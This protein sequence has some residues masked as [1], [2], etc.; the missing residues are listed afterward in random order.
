MSIP[1]WKPRPAPPEIFKDQLLPYKNANLLSKFFVHWIAPVTKV[2]WSRDITIDDLYDLTSDLQSGLLGDKLEA[3]FMK[4][5]PPSRRPAKYRDHL[6]SDS[7]EQENAT[8]ASMTQEIGLSWISR[9]FNKWTVRKSNKGHTIIEGDKIYDQSLFKA[10]YLTTWGQWWWMIVIKSTAI[11]M[12][13]CTRLVMKI[14]LTEITRAHNWHAVAQSGQST[15]G[16][17]PPKSVGYMFGVGIGMVITIMATSNLMYYNYWRARLMGKFIHSAITAMISRKAMRLSGKARVEMTN[18]RITTMLSVDSSFI[19][20]ATQQSSELI[21]FPL[22]VILYMGILIWQL[23]YCALVGFAVLLFTGPLKYW[24]FKHI[25]KL[26][27][28]QNEVIDIRVKFLSEILNNIRAVKLY[29]YESLF[30]EKINGMRKN[31]LGKFQ[32]NNLSNST[33]TATMAFLPTLAAILTFITYALT[34]HEL[35]VATVFSSLTYFGALRTPLADLPQ[36]VTNLS[37]ASVGIRRIGDLLRA[38]E[39]KS[40]IKIDRNSE[41]AIDVTGDFRFDGTPA[42]SPKDDKSIPKDQAAKSRIEKLKIILPRLGMK[43]KSTGIMSELKAPGED[44]NENEKPFALTGL[45]LQIPRG[46]LTCIVGRVGVGKTALLSGLINEMKQVHGHVIFRG[47]VSYVPQ[48]AWVQSGSIRDNITFSESSEEVNIE[49]VNS[50]IDA[51]GLKQDIDMWPAGDLTKIGERGVT[52][53]GGQRQR[54]CIARAAYEQSDVV[55]LDDPL[56]AVDAYVGHHLLEQC[57]FNGPM[58]NR[59]RVLVTHHLDVL[60]KADLILVMDRDDA[61]NGR[62]IQKGTYEE[63]MEQEGTFKNLID[64]YGGLD[65]SANSDKRQESDVS[66][67]KLTMSDKQPASS[68]NDNKLIMDEEKAEGAVSANVYFDYIKSI[69]SFFVVSACI[70]MLVSSQAASILNTLFLGFWSENQFTNLS[71]GAYMGIYGGLGVAMALFN[72]GAIF[73]MFLG[74]IRA[75]FHMFDQAWYKVMRSPTSWH[76]RTP[77]GRIVNRLSKDIEIL[78]DS[79][80]KIWYE[81]LSGALTIIGSLALVLYTYPWVGLVFIPVFTYNYFTVIFYRQT[82][83]E[84]NRLT[85][86][87]RSHIYTNFGEQLA[88][89]PIIRAFKQQDRFQRRFEQSIDTH[90]SAVM[91]GSFSQGFWLGLRITYVSQSLIFAVV[92]FG[93]IFRN[94]ISAAKFGV[95]LNYI[96]QL[97]SVISGLVGDITNAEQMMN[98]VERVHYYTKLETEACSQ[99]SSDPKSDQVWPSSGKISFK[100]VEMRYRPELPLVLKGITF[101]INPGEKVG[102]IGRTGAGK[103]SIAQALF[104]IVEICNGSIEIDGLNLKTL[105][106]DTLRHRL[107]VIPQDSFLFGGTVRDNIDPAGSK[108]DIQLNDAL[109]LIHHDSHATSSLREKFRLD[110]IVASEG[111]NFSAGEKQL[112]ALVRALVKGSKV[113]LLDEATSSVDPET[114]AL[115]Q[116]IIQTEFSDVTLISIAHRLQTVAYYEKIIVMDEGKVVEFDTPINLFEDTSSIF[117]NLCD[118]KNLTKGELLKIREDASRAKRRDDD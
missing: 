42:T 12:R 73:T 64:Q 35:D 17:I 74:G 18:G 109:N 108:S 88:G 45:D 94:S 71:Q 33:M 77:T 60:P 56:S 34:G 97:M 53:S 113:L 67:E 98:T 78:D 29:A 7:K 20:V 4:R 15:Q 11:V 80:A 41:Y 27:K 22:P 38:E 101:D 110:K 76:D 39:L 102:I 103:S 91:M 10:M 115:I 49:K 87:L 58:S 61:S 24:M 83:R 85:S 13:A 104:R 43:A 48:Q 55:L 106:V 72:W 25:S 8:E 63:L 86:L 47:S 81:V 21:T 68:E 26:R 112:L 79:I 107:S 84:L 28:S 69:N 75:S 37:Q 70:A 54:I 14:L 116:R 9:L 30:S 5:I 82:T 32:Q 92:V 89:L 90:L 100:D 117:R 114:D 95:V 93:I 62:I 66:D 105:G 2:A 57:I 51:C 46:S 40:D 96:I 3:N 1:F 31:E 118:T 23:G 16:L 65:P 59:S 19:D 99:L 36:V 6:Q 52:L 111:S 44:Q 50:I